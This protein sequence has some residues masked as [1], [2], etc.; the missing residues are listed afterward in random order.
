[1]APEGFDSVSGTESDQQ[2]PPVKLSAGNGDRMAQALL[3]KGDVYGKQFVVFE[4][5][6]AYPMYVVT[7]TCPD[8]FT[9]RL[10]SPRTQVADVVGGWVMHSQ[11]FRMHTTN[12]FSFPSQ[13]PMKWEHKA[14]SEKNWTLY[15]LE[16]SM[17]LS[18]AIMFISDCDIYNICLLLFKCYP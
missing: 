2:V 9:P 13:R 18:Q 11:K 5:N 7:Y 4:S 3:E 17:Q 14:A 16:H 12:P 6:H 1:M 15:S 10:T 8:D